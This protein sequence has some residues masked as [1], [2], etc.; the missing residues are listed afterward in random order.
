MI[1][2]RFPQS[3]LDLEEKKRKYKYGKYGRGKYVYTDDVAE[4]IEEKLKAKILS[5]FPDAT[6]EYFT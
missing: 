5:I 6:I 1:L 4:E 3:L 2:E